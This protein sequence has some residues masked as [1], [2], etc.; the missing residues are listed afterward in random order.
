[1]IFKKLIPNY[2]KKKIKNIWYFYKLK[3]IDHKQLVKKIK[4]RNLTYLSYQKLFK[5]INSLK[6]VM[7]KK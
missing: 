6:E 5:V 4:E 1:M 2:L 3:K 7:I